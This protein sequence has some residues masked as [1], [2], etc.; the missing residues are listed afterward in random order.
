MNRDR[1]RAD[2]PV[3]FILPI[4]YSRGASLPAAWRLSKRTY[5]P[6]FSDTSLPQPL[7]PA[8]APAACSGPCVRRTTTRFGR[9]TF[10]LA[11]SMI[12]W[13]ALTCWAI[14]S[15]WLWLTWLS[16]ASSCA[17]TAPTSRSHF[18]SNRSYLH[19]H[20]YHLLLS[21]PVLEPHQMHLLSKC[22]PKT[23]AHALHSTAPPCFPLSESATRLPHHAADTAHFFKLTAPTPA[24]KRG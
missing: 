16:P 6:S 13:P 3:V 14:T 4:A 18:Q 2:G 21:K 11:C 17:N 19:S 23:P 20:H 7:P 8:N 24:P 1:L 15:A 22:W 9:G 5:S 12:R 10:L